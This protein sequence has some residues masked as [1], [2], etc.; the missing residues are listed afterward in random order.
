M[1]TPLPFDTRQFDAASIA[2]RANKVHVGRGTFRYRCS[3]PGCDQP[4]YCYTTAHKEFRKFASAFDLR[5]E[6]DPRRFDF[7]EE[8]LC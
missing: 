1:S 6:H 2:W 4:L 5:H 7:C 8:H 3:R